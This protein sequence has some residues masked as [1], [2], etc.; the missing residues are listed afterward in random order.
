MPHHEERSLRVDRVEIDDRHAVEAPWTR[1]NIL[2]PHHPELLRAGDQDAGAGV[3]RCL[4]SMRAQPPRR[5]R[6]PAH[7]ETSRAADRG[8]RGH[9]RPRRAPL[10]WP[11]STSGSGG[12]SRTSASPVPQPT[13]TIITHTATNRPAMDCA[14]ALVS[15]WATIHRRG[16]PSPRTASRLASSRASPRCSHPAATPHR[17]AR[18]WPPAT[19]PTHDERAPPRHA[20]QREQRQAEEC[21]R[22][23]AGAQDREAEQR[24]GM[25]AE[26]LDGRH[27][28]PAW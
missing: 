11:P 2:R 4:G 8:R 13:A 26:L 10:R 21:G 12:P 20:G 19:S 7:R 25:E 3:V 18:R 27:D 5:S 22:P 17:E 6:C 24:R 23:D 9:P 14:W 16:A 1:A 15:R 28:S